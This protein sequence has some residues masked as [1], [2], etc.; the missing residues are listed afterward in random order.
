MN[1]SWLSEV[2]AIP[3][4]L[5]ILGVNVDK[6]NMAQAI[7][8]VS[9]WIGES[10][11]P[12][13]TRYV[14]TPNPEMI[15]AAQGDT[16]FKKVL[17][18]ADL[19][20]PDSARL[21][22]ADLVLRENN[23]FT[24]VLKWPFFIFPKLLAHDFD[25]VA[26]TD[27]MEELV[28]LSEVQGFRI[29]LLGGGKKVAERLG[30]VLGRRYLGL[31]V[32]FASDG[33]VIDREGNAETVDDRKSKIVVEDRRLKVDRSE[34]PSS[35][36]HPQKTTFHS[37][38]SIVKIPPIDILFVAFGHIKQEKWIAKNLDKYPV[39]VMMGVGGAFDYLLGDIPRAPKWARNLGLEWLFR[40][41]LQP[42]RIKR[43][44][45]LIKFVFL[46]LFKKN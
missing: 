34:N 6:V 4:K 25:T 2:E 22:W 28:K 9:Q 36:F 31:K 38:P 42:W 37:L 33:G 18:E 41:V 45:S 23:F 13:K 27:L 11:K 32:V 21:G 8:Q 26:G 16:E 43:F 1:N 44:W 15:V 14:V 5:D 17:N 46:V 3:M 35:L 24:R 39:K 40:L 20:I 29:G 10:A 30:G 12:L 7:E 19:A